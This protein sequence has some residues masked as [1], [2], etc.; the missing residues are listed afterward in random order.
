MPTDP[1][2]LLSHLIEF[3]YAA[4][5]TEPLPLEW[6]L[7]YEAVRTAEGGREQRLAAFFKATEG[8]PNSIAMYGQIFDATP[9]HSDRTSRHRELLTADQALSPQPPI[10][11]CVE[12]LFTRPSLNLLVGDPGS[13]KTYLALDLAVCVAL[14]QPWLGRPV[15]A[16]PVLVVDDDTGFPFWARLKAV[17]RAHQAPPR[18]PL[19]FMSLPGFD[20]RS[21][22]DAAELAEFALSIRAGLIVIDALADV[23]RGGDENSV[24]SVQPVFFHL[25]HLAETCRATLLVLHHT[26]KH[27]HFRGSTSISAGVD[28]ML[29]IESRP[30]DSLIHLRAHKAR[31]VF[32]RPFSARAHFEK[33]RFWLTPTDETQASSAVPQLGSAASAILDYLVANGQ[34]TTPQLMAVINTGT[35]ATIRHTVHELM[36]AGYLDRVD[37]GRRGKIAIFRLSSKG[38]ARMSKK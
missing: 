32:P 38:R 3:G 25:R 4:E 34:A 21:A 10:D 31:D 11:W 33:D 7:A 35:P 8:N 1:A 5:P 36:A 19:N 29:S 12:G 37:G 23:M 15:S 24:L 27:G 13:K 22:E 17:L 14:G 16:S 20:L 18:T 9:D 26:N 28:L 2:A 30:D 6:Q